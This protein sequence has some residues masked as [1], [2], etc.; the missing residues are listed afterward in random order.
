MVDSTFFSFAAGKAGGH[1]ASLLRSPLIEKG[2]NVVL[3]TVFPQVHLTPDVQLG[4]LAG[5]VLTIMLIMVLRFFKSILFGKELISNHQNHK[6][7]TNPSNHH[8]GKEELDEILEFMN[9]YSDDEDDEDVEF[10]KE[11]YDDSVDEKINLND[12]Y[13]MVLVVRN[14]LGM[15]KGKIAAQCGHAVASAVLTA[16]ARKPKALRHWLI[17]GST[18]VAVK[19]QSK[20]ELLSLYKIARKNDIVAEY[21][22]DAGRTQIEPGSLTVLAIGPGPIDKINRITG[23]LKLL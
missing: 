21:I 19:I 4:F 3:H 13:K 15:G 10:V 7:L 9:D 11:P 2:S 8:I 1:I 5:V 18:K 12:D 23:S 22:R 6:S 14:D 20:E 16:L 17:T